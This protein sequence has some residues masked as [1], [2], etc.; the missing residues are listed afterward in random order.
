MTE[1]K[2]R[3]EVLYSAP[4]V[5]ERIRELGAR[6]TRDYQGQSVHLLGILRGSFMFLSDLSKY[7]EV[8]VTL[9]FIALSSYGQE[10]KSSGVVKLQLDLGLSIKDK[11]VIVV[12]DIVDT[13]LTLSYLLKNLTLRAPA[14]VKICT[15]LSKQA[16]R[17]VEVP[18][19]Y[20]GFDIPDAFVIGFGLDYCQRY[21]NLP[22]I[23][24]MH[25]ED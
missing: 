19:D 7:I 9:D 6:I 22:Y 18:V 15:L 21:R 2:E 24:I 1:P 8:P 3:V 13:G 4:Q 17:Q 14:S 16:R 23:G 20:I 12:E 11:H 5:Q 10:T 25:L